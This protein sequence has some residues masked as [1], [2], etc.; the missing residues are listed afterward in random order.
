MNRVVNKLLTTQTWFRKNVVYV[1]LFRKWTKLKLKKLGSTI[2]QVGL[3]HNN[4][5]VNKLISIRLDNIYYYMFICT[6]MNKKKLYFDIG[7]C[8]SLNKVHKYQLYIY[9]Y[10]KIH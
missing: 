8:M 6:Y 4:V 3:K 2:K 5:F 9:I 7:L 1:C 10:K